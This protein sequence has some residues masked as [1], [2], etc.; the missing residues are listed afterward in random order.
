MQHPDR[1]PI[2]LGGVLFAVLWGLFV[3]LGA[4]AILQAA[5]AALAQEIEER[6]LVEEQLRIKTNLLEKLSMQDGLTGIPNRRHFDQRAHAEWRRTLLSETTRMG[7][8]HLA[9]QMRRAVERLAIPHADSS[10]A[11]IVT[12]S[13]GVASHA[14]DRVKTD[15]AH[16][17]HCAD[18]ALYEAKHRGRNQV[19]EEAQSSCSCFASRLA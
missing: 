14:S 6:R 18:Q 2:L 17:Q 16:L 10:V 11:Q 19:Q 13:L 3:L 1:N 15:F 5:N 8:L 7:A 12:L 4:S 9:E